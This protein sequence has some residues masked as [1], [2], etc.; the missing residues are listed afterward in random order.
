MERKMREYEERRLESVKLAS[1]LLLASA[2]TSPRVGGIDEISIHVLDERD[3]IE[4]LAPKPQARER[5]GD[6]KSRGRL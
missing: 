6:D 2:T 1:Q 4:D 3:A 5:P